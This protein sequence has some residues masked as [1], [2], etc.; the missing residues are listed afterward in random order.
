MESTLR[1]PSDADYRSRGVIRKI[2]GPNRDEISGQ[3]RTP[4]NEELR[5]VYKKLVRIV[6]S[7]GEGGSIQI[8]K[9]GLSREC[10]AELVRRAK[11][12]KLKGTSVS[13]LNLTPRREDIWGEWRYGFMNFQPRN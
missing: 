10:T 2:F 13:L 12:V 11:R 8:G 9:G 4:H 7:G 3:F 5:C 1:M 6:K